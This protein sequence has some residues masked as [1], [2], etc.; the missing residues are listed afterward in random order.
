MTH[1]SHTSLQQQQ[2]VQGKPQTGAENISSELK[3]E[4]RSLQDRSLPLSEHSQLQHCCVSLTG[5][6]MSSQLTH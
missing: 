5:T 3:P 4:M 6:K 2:L 1:Y